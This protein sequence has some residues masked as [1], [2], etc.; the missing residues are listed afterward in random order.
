MQSRFNQERGRLFR[1]VRRPGPVYFL[2]SFEPCLQK[3]SFNA[4]WIWRE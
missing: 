2:L 4:N 3:I 1:L